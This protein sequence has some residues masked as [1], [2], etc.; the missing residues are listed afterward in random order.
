LSVLAGASPNVVGQS[1]GQPQQVQ[2]PQA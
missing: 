2:A 1:Y